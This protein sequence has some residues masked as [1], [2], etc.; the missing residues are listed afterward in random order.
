MAAT[1]ITNDN[2]A[3]SSKLTLSPDFNQIWNFSTVFIEVTNIKLHGNPSNGSSADT[4]GRTDGHEDYG[5]APKNKYGKDASANAIKT[6]RGVE[7]RLHSFLTSAVDG[8]EWSASRPGRFDPGKEPRYPFNR[9][10]GGPH[11]WTGHNVVIKTIK[12]HMC[13]R[14]N[15]APF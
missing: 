9:R 12:L 1:N 2:T 14:V 13:A 3:S 7:A 4:C 6:Y 8:D 11:S 10:L 15:S 5:N